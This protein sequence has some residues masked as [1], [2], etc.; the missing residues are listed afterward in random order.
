MSEHRDTAFEHYQNKEKLQLL[1]T[2]QVKAIHALPAG[3][4]GTYIQQQAIQEIRNR[5]KKHERNKIEKMFDFPLMVSICMLAMAHG[6]NE[7]NVA[8][9]LTAE[10]FLLDA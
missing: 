5:H 1:S 7:I 4:K 8:A 10:I 2:S 6:S 3:K 9:P